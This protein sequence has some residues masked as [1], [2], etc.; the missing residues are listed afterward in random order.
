MATGKRRR[1]ARRFVQFSK[2]IVCVVIGGAMGFTVGTLAL[3]LYGTRNQSEIVEVYKE[4][5]RF[6]TIVFG[7]YSG[8]SAY[9]KYVLNRYTGDDD[10]EDKGTGT[11]GNSSWG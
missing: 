11:V 5:M 10:G 4:Y 3:L 9:E 7:C 8:N 1:K 6:S 2:R